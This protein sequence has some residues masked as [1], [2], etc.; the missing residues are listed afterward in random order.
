MPR[1]GFRERKPNFDELK[2]N[3]LKSWL[4]K[5]V[6]LL[7]IVSLLN[8]VAGE[9]LYPVLPLYMA[10]IGYGAVWIGVLEGFAEAIAGLTK[11]WFGE[12]S[13]KRGMRLPFVRLGYLISA[14]SKPLLAAFASAPW[15]LFMRSSD[16][17]G[18]GIRTGARDALLAE[19]A[20]IH[21]GKV[22]GF[23]RSLDTLGAVIG[24]VLALTWLAFHKG[25]GYQSLFYFALIPGLLCVL[26]LF[27]VK[28]K[29][30][31]KTNF[32]LSRSPF[33]SFSYW[34]RATPAY[35]KLTGALLAFT[36]FNSSDMFLLLMIKH[37]FENGITIYFNGPTF[38]SG[39]MVV[40]GFYIFYNI[41]Y[42]L[43]SYPAGAIADKYGPKRMLLIGF[44]CFAL[45][46][47]GIGI[48][49]ISGTANLAFVLA[50]FSIYGIY[51][52]CTDGVSK[53][54]ISV[55][56]RNED[57]GLALGLFSGLQSFATLVASVTAGLAWTFIHPAAV[58]FS[59]AAMSG[60]II[61]Y[62][63]FAVKSPDR[64]NHI[65]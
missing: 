46:Y 34:K 3:S 24:P 57:K 16:R 11:G 22:F 21:K 18:K 37:L 58:F 63:T 26:L 9:L 27:F 64:N 31:A 59:A 54:W 51:A 53:A 29:K 47:C 36:L 38:I 2:K 8:D 13:D 41:I 60:I 12:W 6:L 17:L 15:A 5:T 49:S 4:T 33:S 43:V 32:T 40:V 42:A 30:T 56:C 20:G 45:A 61:F 1:L 14:L 25:E 35:R 52:A 23:H 65:N 10:G 55:L 62:I 50:C 44:I 39:D 28:E 19:E 7:S 48:A